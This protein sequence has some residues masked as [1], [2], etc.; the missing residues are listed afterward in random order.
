[1]PLING[2]KM[3]CEPCI[4]GHRST[5]CTHANERLMVPVRKPGRPLSSCP[6]PSSRPCSCAAVTAA[7]PRKQKCRCGT[8]QTAQSDDSNASNGDASPPSPP[9]ASTASFR[10]Q[11][12]ASKIAPNRKPSVDLAGL[13]RMDASQLNIMPGYTG[14]QGA[15]PVPN[16][17]MTPLSDMSAY[18]MGVSTPGSSFSPES[19][20]FPPMFP[21]P[22][23][24]PMMTPS[25]V[26]SMTNGHAES[27]NGSTVANPAPKSGGCCGGGGKGSTVQPQMPS[28]APSTNG[29]PN[30]K[31]KSCCSAKTESPPNGTPLSSAPT[32]G[33]AHPLSGVMIA[34]FQHPM[35]ITNGMY[36]YFSHPTIFNYPPQFGSFLQPLQP[37]QWKQFMASMSFAQP[38]PPNGFRMAGPAPYAASSMV[39]VPSTPGGASWTSHQCSCGDGCQCIGCAAHPYNEATQNY[40]RSAYNTMMEDGSKARGHTNGTASHANGTASHANGSAD[41]IHDPSTRHG[42][43]EATTPVAAAAEGAVSPPAPQTPSDG[44]SGLSEEQTLSAN[45]FFFVSYP[46]GDS[47]AG[48]T[49]SCPCGDDCQCIGCVIHNNPGPEQTDEESATL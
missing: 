35:A 16:G 10:V 15:I 20:M 42:S 23:Q 11:K 45:D 46:F 7:I 30:G 47:C 17:Q 43:N 34:P 25:A 44:T 4:R 27:T 5:K 21:Y 9:K 8:S 38:V 39:N 31:A 19:S 1:M 13:G 6:H 49:A 12:P 29:T 36:P 28:P 18:A 24:P 40:V 3:A 33:P 41:G 22:M 2:Q 48:D 37:E 26:K 14:L 32:A